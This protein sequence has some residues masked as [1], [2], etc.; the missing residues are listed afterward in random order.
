MRARAGFES[1]ATRVGFTRDRRAQPPSYGRAVD[2]AVDRFEL[3]ARF[4]TDEHGIIVNVSPLLLE[5]LGADGDAD[6]MG[7][8]LSDLFVDPDMATTLVRR[9]TPR[10]TLRDAHAEVKRADGTTIWVSISM[11]RPTEGGKVIGTM[12]DVTHF[13]QLAQ[14]LFRSESRYRSVF[15]DLP[16][17]MWEL[18]LTQAWALLHRSGYAIVAPV[19]LERELMDRL[20]IVDA[21]DAARAALGLSSQAEYVEMLVPLATLLGGPELMSMHVQAFLGSPGPLVA[22]M[23]GHSA[24]GGE[25]PWNVTWIAPD[26]IGRRDVSRTALAV[27]PRTEISL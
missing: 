21:N 14:N 27:V 6:L 23:T 4:T 7:A 5:T 19:D 11:Q 25:Q 18:D 17:P 3:N 9:L 10:R 1:L 20:R 22:E 16:A 12:V 15:M 26:A 24:R 13:A 8:P 2:L